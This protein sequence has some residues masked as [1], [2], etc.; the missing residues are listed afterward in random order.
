MC[1]VN[2]RRSFTS[3]NTV[4]WICT[5]M[6][7]LHFTRYCIRKYE[8][9]YGLVRQSIFLVDVYAEIYRVKLR[10]SF[11]SPDPV[12]WN[13]PEN[14]RMRISYLWTKSVRPGNKATHSTELNDLIMGLDFI[15]NSPPVFTRL[16]NFVRATWRNQSVAEFEGWQLNLEILYV[17]WSNILCNTS[18]I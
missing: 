14:Y 11:P 6:T 18:V 13:M 15:L 3:L 17:H 16:Y 10:Q 4:Y 8:Y 9:V 5:V 2:M 7:K 1:E 12:Y